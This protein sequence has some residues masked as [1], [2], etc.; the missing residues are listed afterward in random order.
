M[1]YNEGTG[2]DINLAGAY[3]FKSVHLTQNQQEGGE[4]RILQSVGDTYQPN[5]VDD[6]PHV[7]RATPISLCGTRVPSRRPASLLT[8][9]LL[10]FELRFR[11]STST[12]ANGPQVTSPLPGK[13]P[14]D[15]DLV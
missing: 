2:C 1:I 15:I 11:P 12:Y 14:D 8:R 3:E 7:S 10:S 13:Y 4:V 5:P 6:F 9:D